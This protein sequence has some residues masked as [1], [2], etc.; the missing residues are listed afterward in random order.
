MLVKLT[1]GTNHQTFHVILVQIRVH[2]NI[3][4][5]VASTKISNFK[6]YFVV[7]L[8]DQV[9]GCN[10]DADILN[11]LNVLLRKCFSKTSKKQR[12]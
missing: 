11:G 9:S 2:L 3:I 4:L 1:L 6:I 12:F 7:V 10:S 5:F 8:I